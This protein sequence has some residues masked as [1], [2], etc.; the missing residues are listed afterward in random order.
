MLAAASLRLAVAALFLFMTPPLAADALPRPAGL[1]PEIA[2]WRRIFTEVSTDQALVHDNRFLG[3][4]YE[5]IDLPGEASPAKQERF[6]SAARGKY[7][8]ILRALASG[9]RDGLTGEESRVLKLWP[10]DVRSSELRAAAERVRFQQ[11]LADRF[12]AGLVRSGQWREHILKNLRAA[13]VPEDLV[14]LP[15]VESSFNPEAYSYVGASGLWQFTRDTGRRF[16][17]VD[18]VVDERR[19]PYESSRAAARLLQYNYSVIGSWPLAITGYNHGLGGMRKAVQRMGT[20]DIEVIV[21]R[22]DGPAFGFASR[23]FYVSFLAARDVDRDPEKYFGPVRR[24]APREELIVELPDY[25]KAE[26]IERAFGVSRTTLQAYNPALLPPVWEGAKYVPRGFRLRLPGGVIDTPA[27]QV[28]DAIPQS[29]RFAAQRPDQ[30]HR[31]GRGETL[32][33]IAARYGTTVAKLMAANGLR[34]ARRVRAGQTLRL[35]V[36]AEADR[37]PVVVA[38]APKPK[39]QLEPR[40]EPAA[41]AAAKPAPPP[42][43]PSVAAVAEAVVATAL[44]V[45]PPAEKPRLAKKPEPKPAA[46]PAQLAVVLPRTPPTVVLA[47]FLALQAPPAAEAQDPPAGLAVAATAPAS[48]LVT[49]PNDYLVAEDGSVEVQAT[50]TL[51]HY[52]EWLQASPEA[53]REAN[54]WKKSRQIVLGQRVRLVFD[55][56][57]RESFIERRIAHHRGLQEDFFAR[58]RITDTTEHKLRAGESLWSLAQQKYKVPVWLLRQYNP[59]LK[60][61]QVRPG[62]RVIFP[63]LQ[64][65]AAAPDA[66][67]SAVARAG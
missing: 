46:K 45:A 56:V 30:M 13:G 4:V 62:T 44:P 17:Q 50:E 32:S 67:E 61:D 43:Q 37:A 19:D 40:A 49:D 51:S 58:Y 18:H 53:L 22:Y 47:P 64:A 3:V 5:K 54:G 55:K 8:R 36:K 11:G 6:S 57:G 38:S 28:L 39:P 26:T 34:D 12:H 9:K 52:A 25:M 29:Q 24:K 15:H 20:D 48:A 21:R 1:E 31:V 16:M 66:T 14:A 42:V 27:E 59:D 65:V 23:N 7:E 41:T 60:L 2:F 10:A 35:P 33:G 63:R